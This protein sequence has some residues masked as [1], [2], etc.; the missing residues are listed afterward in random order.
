MSFGQLVIGP[1]GSGKTMYC[2]AMFEFLAA[3]GRK[4]VIVNIDPAND[5][6]PY[7]ADVDISELITLEEVMDTL[8]LGPNGGL[9]YCIEYLEKNFDWLIGKLQMFKDCYVIIDCPG[10]VELY[11]HHSSVRSI[12][13]SLLKL[14]YRL[15]AVHLVDSHYCSDP[16][17]F[18]SVLLISLSTMLQIELPHINVL[19]KVDLLEK[20]GKLAFNLEYYTEV[21]N[22]SYLLEKLDD[23]PFISKYKKLNKELVG[24][25][26]D[27]SLVSFSP[28]NIENKKTISSVLAAIDK[29]NGYIFKA[30][31]ENNLQILLSTA[32]KNENKSDNLEQLQQMYMST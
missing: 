6:I 27:Y 18:I 29:A 16:G 20:Y 28:L 9:I 21:L 13:A 25:I 23:D 11:T 17:K 12:V 19:S 26:E 10:Q 22:L 7:K 24:I 31:E 15:A 3:I 30:Q 32:M 1:P 14:D 5:N 8:H 2:K 4:A